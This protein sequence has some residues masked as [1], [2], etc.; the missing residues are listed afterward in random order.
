MTPQKSVKEHVTNEGITKGKGHENNTK[1]EMVR[2]YTTK[3]KKYIYCLDLDISR[4]MKEG[5][6]TGDMEDTHNRG[7]TNGSREDIV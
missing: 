3:W 5:K 4:E 7:R 1:M 2:P 6:T